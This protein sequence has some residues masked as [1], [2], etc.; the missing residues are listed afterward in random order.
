[1]AT[2]GGGTAALLD[3]GVGRRPHPLG[4]HHPHGPDPRHPVPTDEQ[5]EAAAAAGVEVVEVVVEDKKGALD[6]GSDVITTRTSSITRGAK[7][8]P[9]KGIGKNTLEHRNSRGRDGA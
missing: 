3:G 7:G 6:S 5:G 4:P 2:T 8:S 1:M 9:V